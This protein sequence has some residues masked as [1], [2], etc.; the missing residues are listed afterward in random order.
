[1]K[2]SSKSCWNSSRKLVRRQK[3]NTM[4]GLQ[5]KLKKISCY[6]PVNRLFIS[7]LHYSLFIALQLDS[8]YTVH[9]LRV[10]PLDSLLVLVR[11]RHVH[12]QRTASC[13][14]YTEKDIIP[15]IPGLL[16]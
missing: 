9:W 14:Y 15:Y 5:E 16:K 4:T 11:Y 3:R 13:L 12:R 2:A 6:W 8:L 7:K 10:A 1:M